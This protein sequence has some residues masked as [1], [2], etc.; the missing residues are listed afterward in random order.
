MVN[1][2]LTI[3]RRKVCDKHNQQAMQKIAD[4][5]HSLSILKQN[6]KEKFKGQAPSTPSIF[7][8]CRLMN[9]DLHVH[10]MYFRAPVTFVA[11]RDTFGESSG[12]SM[13]TLYLG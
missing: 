12:A 9:I 2:M 8:M 1:L 10:G 7:K 3:C 6:K 11:N 4:D 5:R 13:A